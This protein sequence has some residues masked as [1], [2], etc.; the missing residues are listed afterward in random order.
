[1]LAIYALF[2]NVMWQSG[3]LPSIDFLYYSRQP[4]HVTH[5]SLKFFDINGEVT[6]EPIYLD[7]ASQWFEDGERYDALDLVNKL[8]I[9]LYDGDVATAE[10]LHSQLVDNYFVHI[11]SATYELVLRVV[12]PVEKY[13]LEQD[14][15]LIDQ[16]IQRYQ[17]TRQLVATH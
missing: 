11:D 12:N 6:E 14:E 1:M 7:A 5:Y 16:V 3:A 2:F 4:A 10:Q 15:L 8:G 9:A 13:N 17:F